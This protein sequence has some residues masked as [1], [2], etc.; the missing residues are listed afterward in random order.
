MEK[1]VART[2]MLFLIIVNTI[3]L[4]DCES[5]IAQD[6]CEFVIGEKIYENPLSSEKD[7]E[8]VVIE[9][10]K[11]GQPEITFEGGRMRI[12]SNVHFLLWFP[13]DLPGDFAVSW[14]FMPK[15]DDGLAMFWF[16]A[17]GRK[18]ED[19]FD[20]SLAKRAGQ[21]PQYHSGDINAYH[22][23]YF[24]RNEWDDS[25][26]NTVHLRK[27]YGKKLVA[28]G[29]NPIPNVEVEKVAKDL[30]DPY[31][32][33]LIKY[34][35]H[36]RV[37]INDMVILD[38]EDDSPYQDGK[39]GFRQMANLVAEYSN[40][41]I[42]KVLK[43]SE[44]V[45]ERK[46]STNSVYQ[47]PFANVPE[48]I[49]AL[50]IGNS[51]TF[52]HD[53]PELVKRMAEDGNLNLK[54]T[55]TAVTYGGKILKDHWRLRTQNFIN[56]STLT[57]EEQEATINYLEETI[58]NDPQDNYAI[59][60]LGK[61]KELLRAISAGE[62]QKWDVVILQSSKYDYH[63][64]KSFYIEYAPLFAEIIKAQGAMVVLYETAS[65]T[66]N[67]LPLVSPPDREAVLAK[68]KHI[69]ELQVFRA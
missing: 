25:S 59:T 60:A 48:S 15:N 30:K 65:L 62:R 7:I 41:K 54:F 19:L 29:P 17:K 34:G 44:L 31:R 36:I 22:L 58:S 68:E 26:I 21:Y 51:Y 69:A 8:D 32:V 47:A 49:N 24:R 4:F 46:C 37:K 20:E 50:F 1:L 14:D 56:Q 28:L 6:K 61:H 52:R 27:S 23:S 66:Q 53:L 2:F 35:R 63:G 18:G 45:P 3:F 67:A 40:L 55:F 13:F 57:V 5:A 64:A 33:E 38:W 10:S 12:K 43:T 16:C 11:A 9:S 39:I 42:N